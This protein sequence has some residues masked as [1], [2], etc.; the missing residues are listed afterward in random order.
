MSESPAKGEVALDVYER[1]E[2]MLPWNVRKLVSGLTVRPHFFGNAGCFWYLRRNPEG[3][4]F[5]TVDPAG[6]YVEPGFDH[7]RLAT[8]LQ[9]RLGRPV[10]ATALPFDTILVNGDSISFVLD[11][12]QWVFDRRL[13][14][15]TSVEPTSN[16]ECKIARVPSPDGRY[17]AFIRNFDVWV[18]ENDT[19]HEENLTID[20]AA[21]R[22]Y[23]SPLETPLVTAG[24]GKPGR[25]FLVWSPD[26]T[27]ILTQRIDERDCPPLPFLQALPL[28]GSSRPKVHSVS[29]AMAGDADVPMARALI[30]HVETKQVVV[31]DGDPIPVLYYGSPLDGRASWS[32]NSKQI[33]IVVSDRGF[34]G[35][36]LL[37]A[38]ADTGESRTVV[39]EQSDVGVDPNGGRWTTMSEF[40]NQTVLDRTAEVLWWS[41]R[42]GWPHLYLLDAESGAT[43]RQVTAG[44]WCVNEVVHVDQDDRQVYF[45]ASGRESG[46][47]VYLSSLYRVS[48]D[49][50]EPALLTPDDADHRVR[51]C[52]DGRHFVVTKSRWD[53]DPQTS[54]YDRNGLDVL[55]LETANV[56]RLYALGW[57][58]PQR[59]RLKGRDG[60]SEIFGLLFTPSADDFREDLPILD[61]IYGGP[62]INFAG[63][64]FADSN[65]MADSDGISSFFW[66]AQ[67]LAELG[68]AVVI[69]DGLG[70][71]GRGKTWSNAAWQNLADAGIPDHIA[72]YKQ[73]DECDDRIDSQRVGILGHSAGGYAS[74]RA[75]LAHPEIYM[76]CVSSAGN[77]DHRLDK[78]IWVERFMGLPVGDHYVE[79]TNTSIAGNLEGKLLLVHGDMDENL[80]IA[81]TMALA[82]ALIEADKDFDL[83]IMPNRTHLFVDDPYFTRVRWNYF[84]RHVLALEPPRGYSLR[85]QL[86]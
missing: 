64:S 47:D 2:Q 7:A 57:R 26:S 3:H 24:L 53:H 59:L 1:A 71:A 83:L 77:H 36:R 22:H 13:G 30:V 46:R 20:G 60:C 4:S 42:D 72:A 8:L 51:A 29:Y 43:V 70:M 17:L 21:R 68:F 82:N 19:G 65:R 45:T 86:Q 63:P 6:H 75:I 67:A 48:L 58:P 28:D 74:V 50:G 11:Q 49:G 31:V 41:E 40:H 69:L 15:I 18:R 81:S 5:M 44:R 27:R 78:A 56:E 38:N 54:I 14:A 52:P 37:E 80:H 66:H 79:Q 9:R 39:T 10:D 33:R 12:Q 23:G 62:H 76:A 61:F 55:T 73:L 35:Y 16:E 32:S 84:V 34:R 85:S 25:T